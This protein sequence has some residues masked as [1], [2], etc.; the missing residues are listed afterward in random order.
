MQI[1]INLMFL[2]VSLMVFFSYRQGIKD[3]FYINNNLPLKNNPEKSYEN[4]LAREY[5]KMLS[6]EFEMAG[7]ENDK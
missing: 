6:Y 7:E 2:S 3:S 4:E 5:D 1:V